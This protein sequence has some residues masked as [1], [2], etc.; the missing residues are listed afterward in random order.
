VDGVIYMK[1]R[2]ANKLQ[3]GQFVNAEIV[4][5]LDYDLV[6]KVI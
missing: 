2:G 1:G 4:E 5:G 3:T 6:A